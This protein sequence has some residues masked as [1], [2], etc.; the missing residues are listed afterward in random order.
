MSYEERKDAFEFCIREIEKILFYMPLGMSE[1][2][3]ALYL[4]D[5]ICQNFEY[6]EN[7]KSRDMYGMLKNRRGTCQGYAYLFLELAKRVG[8]E[9]DVVYSDPM[10]HIWN[11]VKIDGEWYY[12]DLTWD[13]GNDFYRVNHK[14]FLFSELEAEALGYYGYKRREG[15][16]CNSGKY[17]GEYLNNISTPMAY[18]EGK[19]YFAENSATV[20]GVSI[21]NEKNDTAEKVISVDG[22]W[23]DENN[24]IFAN[25]FSSV[26]SVGG[27][28]YFNTKDKIYKY[29]GGECVPIYSAPDKKQIYYLVTDG[30]NIYFSLGSGEMKNISV[31]SDGDV[32]GDGKTNLLDIINLSLSIEKNDFSSVNKFC[33]DMSGNAKIESEDL[34]ILRGLLVNLQD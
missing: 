29:F 7:Y 15:V 20:R 34:D 6:D 9:C 11:V 22:Y 12:I 18:F 10:C 17:F 19:W 26:V 33:A 1:F 13:D 23:R 8:L 3:K 16:V 30:K 4:H 27:D 31:D 24:K 2:D 28:V 21:Y 14:K 25:C 5:Y 32:N